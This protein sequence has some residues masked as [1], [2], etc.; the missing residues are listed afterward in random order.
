ML[1]F[2]TAVWV[3]FLAARPLALVEEKG[4]DKCCSEFW[5]VA[6]KISTN[7]LSISK[8]MHCG[9]KQNFPAAGGLGHQ[10]FVACGVGQTSHVRVRDWG[11]SL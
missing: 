1:L 11:V 4:R 2:Q 10:H 7:V 3:P 6:L 8:K 5:A 9:P